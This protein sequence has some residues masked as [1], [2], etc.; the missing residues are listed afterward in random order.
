MNE[1]KVILNGE[2]IQIDQSL[3]DEEI[4]AYIQS[5]KNVLLKNE[6]HNTKY[7]K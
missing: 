3:T 7:N 5:T 4:K 6:K 2:T 1:K